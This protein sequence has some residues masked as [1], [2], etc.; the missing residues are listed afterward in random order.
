MKTLKGEGGQV[1][2][3]I[4]ISGG[5][6]LHVNSKLTNKIGKIFENS[7]VLS[8]ATLCYT[9]TLKDIYFALILFNMC[10]LTVHAIPVV[11]ASHHTL[12]IV[13]KYSIMHCWP[14]P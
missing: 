4:F 6:S 13:V 8:H 14:L 5:S 2:L 12:R 10:M 9:H 7:S 3:T 1:L 11:M